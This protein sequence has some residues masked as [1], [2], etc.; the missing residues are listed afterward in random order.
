MKRLCYCLLLALAACQRSAVEEVLGTVER[1]RLELVAEAHEPIAELL[2]REG[3]HVEVGHVLLR[4]TAGAMQARLE[5]LQAQATRAEQQLRELQR[6]PRVQEKEQA[7]AQLEAASSTLNTAEKEFQR[8]QE[9]FQAKLQSQAVLDQ[10]RSTRDAALATRRQAQLALQLLNEGTRV[11]QIQQVQ[12]AVDQAHAALAELQ[13]SATR[14]TITAPR[15]GVVEAL[16]YKLGERPPVAQPVVILLADDRIYA[17]VYVP[18][19]LRTQ[20]PAG[21][22]VQV[23][24]D[25]VAQPIAGTVRYVSAQAAFTPYYALTQQDRTRLSYLAEI[26]LQNAQSLPVGLPVQVSLMQ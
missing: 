21:T 17:R 2:V 24:V 10:A 12:A 6:G 9:L 13:V 16:P 22:T 3:D 1:D 25:G 5:Q 14:Y 26:D 15:S 7:K 20:Y 19:T 18:E 11:E 4:Q 8:A 23:R